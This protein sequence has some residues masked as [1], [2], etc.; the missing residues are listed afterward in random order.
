MFILVGSSIACGGVPFGSIGVCWGQAKE[1]SADGP[2]EQ[3]LGITQQ[4]L[5]GKNKS[6]SLAE[7]SS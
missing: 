6:I 2:L 5:A 1:S 3:L 4:I 7:D